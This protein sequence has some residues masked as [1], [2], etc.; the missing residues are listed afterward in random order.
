MGHTILPLVFQCICEAQL[1]NIFLLSLYKNSLETSYL[2]GKLQVEAGVGS[3][4]VTLSR[5][6]SHHYT[7]WTY[8]EHPVITSWNAQ[9]HMFLPQGENKILLSWFLWRI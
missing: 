2:L 7:L 5:G 4:D 8:S 3:V 9:A 1:E 6:V